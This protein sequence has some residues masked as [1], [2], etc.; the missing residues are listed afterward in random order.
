VVVW[1]DNNGVFNHAT[2]FE[3]NRCECQAKCRSC[4]LNQDRAT[5]VINQFTGDLTTLPHNP[6]VWLTVFQCE[7]YDFVKWV[8]KWNTAQENGEPAPTGVYS[9]STNST[10]G[11]SDL[12]AR[13]NAREAEEAEEA[14]HR[15]HR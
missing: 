12:V 10:D 13:H 8:V 5:I 1:K 9:Y 3:R 4:K 15:Q 2:M 14:W 11:S 6:Q 7:L